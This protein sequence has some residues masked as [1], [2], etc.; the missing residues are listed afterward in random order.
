MMCANK[1]KKLDF[2]FLFVSSLKTKLVGFNLINSYPLPTYKDF[3]FINGLLGVL[4]L[5]TDLTDFF[6]DVSKSSEDKFKVRTKF[7]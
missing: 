6:Q 7:N 1:R 2:Y 4:S 3:F 5:N